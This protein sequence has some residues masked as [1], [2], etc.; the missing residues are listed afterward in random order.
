MG[1]AWHLSQGSYCSEESP[2]AQRRGEDGADFALSFYTLL[3]IREREDRD[4]G[5][6][7]PEAEAA[8]E[9]MERCCH[10]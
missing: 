10:S 7:E 2:G 1:A 5:S 3:I 6:E 8:G 4:S 9:D